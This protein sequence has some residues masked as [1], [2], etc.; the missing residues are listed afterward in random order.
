MS[1]K[2]ER[3]VPYVT[4]DEGRE[5][6]IVFVPIEG[7]DTRVRKKVYVGRCKDHVDAVVMFNEAM[8]KV[9]GERVGEVMGRRKKVR[10]SALDRAVKEQAQAQAKAQSQAQQRMDEED[11]GI[12]GEGLEDPVGEVGAGDYSE[13]LNNL[14]E[15]HEGEE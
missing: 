4:W 1:K 8:E 15:E 13:L 3:R 2:A 12:F 7:E 9:Y 11:E 10:G 14:F 6:W 5:E